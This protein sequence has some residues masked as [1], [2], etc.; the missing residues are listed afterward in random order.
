[1]GRCETKR[2]RWCCAGKMYSMAAHVVT[3]QVMCKITFIVF[4]VLI[5]DHDRTINGSS[6]NYSYFLI[7]CCFGAP[8]MAL[9]GRFLLW[10]A[11]FGLF[12]QEE[13]VSGE[14]SMKGCFLIV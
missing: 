14:R 13:A 1:M 7:S 4:T 5:Y 3:R 11:V 9:G 6:I 10:V 2:N 8:K 12:V